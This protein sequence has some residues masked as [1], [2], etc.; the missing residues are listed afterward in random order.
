MMNLRRSKHASA[1]HSRRKRFPVQIA[2]AQIQRQV[3]RLI[4]RSF[5][6]RKMRLAILRIISLPQYPELVSPRI[7]ENN[8]SF[9]VQDCK[10]H[11]SLNINAIF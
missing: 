2:C 9:L 3:V 5:V 6:L 1:K 8:F 11:Q 7:L 10:Y 4:E